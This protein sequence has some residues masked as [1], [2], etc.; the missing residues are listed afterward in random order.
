MP[1]HAE[2]DGRIIRC[3]NNDGVYIIGCQMPDDNE[4]IRSY[5][6]KKLATQENS[7]VQ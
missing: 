6:E 5:V 2:L 4:Y 1:D 7:G 3:S